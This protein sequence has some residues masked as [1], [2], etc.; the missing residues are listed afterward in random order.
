[1]SY[2]NLV[3]RLFVG[4][5]CAKDGLEFALPD[6]T[7]PKGMDPEEKLECPHCKRFFQR[8]YYD[9]HVNSHS[10]A[11]NWKCT[12][13]PK[14]YIHKHDLIRHMCVTHEVTLKCN[15]CEEEFETRQDLHNHSLK[16][17]KKR[18]LQPQASS[19]T[20]SNNKD[21]TQNANLPVSTA[22]TDSNSADSGQQEEQNQDEVMDP[23]APADLDEGNK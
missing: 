11:R 18:G 23:P 12:K 6:E 17:R 9:R 14:A 10:L 20:K 13:C 3:K 7:V 21:Q 4:E 15:C 1:M 22:E 16:C 2:L 19:N 8:R 5:E